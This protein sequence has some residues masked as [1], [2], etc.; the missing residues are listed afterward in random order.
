MH[1]T[2]TA[3]FLLS[4]TVQD[5]LPREWHHPWWEGLPT[6]INVVKVIPHRLAQRPLF[7]MI[8]GYV[9]L[10]ITTNQLKEAVLPCLPFCSQKKAPRSL[11]Q[12]R[13]H[14]FPS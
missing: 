5:R 4:Y 10:T 1:A 13:R 3:H 7:P 9:R 11:M 12:S 14:T 8:L 2:F 6:L